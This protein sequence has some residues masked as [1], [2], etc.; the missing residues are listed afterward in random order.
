MTRVKRQ[1]VLAD[2]AMIRPLSRL[3]T[4]D[5]GIDRFLRNIVR[6]LSFCFANNN[7]NNNN[8]NKTQEQFSFTTQQ[9]PE[10]THY[11]GSLPMEVTKLKLVMKMA[12]ELC[13]CITI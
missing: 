3:M 12:M 1:N 6:K 13:P 11:S 2:Q 5:D 10:I 4:N 9:K 8:N 7:D